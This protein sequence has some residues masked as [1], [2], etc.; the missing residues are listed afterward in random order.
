MATCSPRAAAGN[1]SDSGNLSGALTDSSTQLYCCVMIPAID[2]A[3]GYLPHGIHDASWAEV[4]PR[5]SQNGHRQRLTN[6][7]LSALHNLAL[8]GCR[9]MLLDGSFVSSKDL[10]GDYDGAWDPVGVDPNLLDPVLLDFRNKRAAMKAKY[11]GELFPATM[12]AAPGVRFREFFLTDRYGV[13]KGVVQIDL[14]S[15]P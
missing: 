6:G 7:L 14:G 15:L 11:G 2:E 10:P 12:M 4:A 8:A 9:V 5:F 3:T 1:D 13:P